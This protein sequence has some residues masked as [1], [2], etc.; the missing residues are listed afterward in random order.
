M[1]VVKFKAVCKLYANLI[2]NGLRTVDE[3]PLD[4]KQGTYISLCAKKIISK[5]ITFK[6]VCGESPDVEKY[7]E[8]ICAGYCLTDPDAKETII[9]YLEDEGKGYLA[10]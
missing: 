7:N 10:E 2:I 3:V 1:A 5:S 8:D 9:K 6:A 4:Y